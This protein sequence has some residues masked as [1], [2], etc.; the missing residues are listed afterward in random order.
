MTSEELQNKVAQQILI[1]DGAMGTRL[2][3][4]TDPADPPTA[5]ELLN[6]TRPDQVA[7]VHQEYVEAGADLLKTNT[8]GT[9]RLGLRALGRED[10]FE[11]INRAAVRIARDVADSSDRPLLIAGSIG[12]LGNLR[13]P[14]D[15]IRLDRITAEFEKQARILADAGVDL[16][17]LETMSDYREAVAALRGAQKTG[18]AVVAQVSS[19]DGATLD[20]HIEI[21]NA[22]RRLESEGAAMVGVNCRIGPDAM[23]Q[24]TRNL[25]R[26]ASRPLSVMPNAGNLV[27][28]NYSR[29]EVVG[30]PDAFAALAREASDLGVGMLGGCCYT[31]GEHIAVLRETLQSGTS[32]VKPEIPRREETG[33]RP[34]TSFE[35]KL[36]AGKF[37]VCVEVDPPTDEEVESDPGIL[38]YKIDGARYLDTEAGVDL[39]TIADHTMG[40]PWLD[41][42]PFAEALKPHLSRA[43]ILLH[44]TCRNKAETDVTGNFASF[45]LYGYRNILVITGDRPLEDKS[46]YEYSSVNLMKRIRKDH[47]D[48][49]FLAC[50][51]DHNRGREREGTG[52]IE[53]EIKRL[54]RKIDAGAQVALTQPLYEPERVRILRE[55][56]RDLP[57]KILPGVMPILSPQHARTVN[58]FPGIHVPD[59]VIERMEA[60]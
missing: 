7:K 20:G 59:S 3:T 49:F 29:L 34:P 10:A 35:E 41:G 4:L 56:T 31:T 38:S 48:H 52:G 9:S 43:D 22:V 54:Q 11:E 24:V 44:Y 17:L 50:S 2:R 47:G 12:P 26:F 19:A 51:F 23:L 46:F 14:A 5:P 39:I 40:R 6:L 25:S 8:F 42:F 53:Q 21:Y 30:S 28:D 18:L 15:I 45:K 55:M 1:A 32:V 36:N 37:V 58:Q 33:H 13:Y 60:A 57:I 16:I 27:V